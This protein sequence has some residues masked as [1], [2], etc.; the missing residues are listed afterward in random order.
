MTL[1]WK[2]TTGALIQTQLGAVD[3]VNTY[4]A[5]HTVYGWM[6]GADG[7]KVLLSKIPNLLNRRIKEL[8]L[9]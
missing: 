5:A 8:R 9:D 1:I 7:A 6:E 2:T 4:S 3:I